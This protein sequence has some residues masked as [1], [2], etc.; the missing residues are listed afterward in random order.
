MKR[1]IAAVLSTATIL[2]S[3]PVAASQYMGTTHEK[4]ELFL[5]NVSMEYNADGAYGNTLSFTY[6]IFEHG[7][8]NKDGH[9][10]AQRET[11][12]HVNAKS[13]ANGRWFIKLANRTERKIPATSTASKKMLGTV[14]NLLKGK[15][16]IHY[17]GNGNQVYLPTGK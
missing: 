3:S 6:T 16:S 5:D 7:G 9:V 17:D 10:V 13:C 14:C 4:D 1:L 8:L 12:A 11:N 15:L 2:M